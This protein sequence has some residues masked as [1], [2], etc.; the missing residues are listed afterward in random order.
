MAWRL[1]G[2]EPVKPLGHGSTGAITISR[3]LATGTAVAIKYLSKDVYRSPD[4]ADRFRREAAVLATVENPHLAQVYEYVEGPD[5]AA[6]VT[7]L[8]DGV[9]LREILTS[10]AGPIEPEAA[11]FVTMGA[12]LGLT[13]THRRGIV[14]RDV[15]PEN[16]LIDADGV[17]KVVDVGLAGRSRRGVPAGGDPRYLAPELWAGQPASTASDVYAVTAT[18]FECLTGKPPRTSDGKPLG[19]GGMAAERDVATLPPAEL[20]PRIRRLI[21]R[22]LAVT[23]AMRAADASAM[24]DDLEMAALGAY[25]PGWEAIGRAQLINRVA[26][27][28]DAANATEPPVAAPMAAASLN[29]TTRVLV[30]VGLLIAL[31][32]GVLAVSSDM[33]FPNKRTANPTTGLTPVF[34]HTPVASP[35]PAVPVPVSTTGGDSVAPQQPTGLRVTSRSQTAVS[36]DWNPSRDDVKV[37]GYIVERAGQRVGTTYTPGFIDVSLAANTKYAFTVTAF[38][39]A[40]NRSPNSAIVSAMTLTV[41]DTA[42]PT[43]PTGLHSTGRSNNTIVLAWAGSLDNIGVAGY[44][45]FRDGSRVATVTQPNFADT[46]LAPASPHTYQVRAFDATNNASANSAPLT[47]ATLST[48]DRQPPSVPTHLVADPTGQTAINLSWYASTDNVGVT[49]YQVFRDGWLIQPA[50]GTSFVDDGLSPG[51]RYTYTVKAF[52]AAGKVSAAS[53]GASATTLD[54]PSGPPTDTPTPTP[55]QTQAPT[56]VVL[57]V[58]LEN[59]VD[60]SDTTCKATIRATV[61]V[62][63]GPLTVALHYT[64]D[65]QDGD[66]QVPVDDSGTATVTLGSGDATADGT[67]SVIDSASNKGD[68]AAWSAPV[69]CL[70]PPPPP[71]PSDSPTNA[72]TGFA[73]QAP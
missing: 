40:G 26:P 1:P 54:A 68:S 32:V 41:P 27:L 52:D 63:G 58:S 64:I 6:I 37:A 24:L 5:S 45:V 30:A 66:V 65:G 22:D 8:V 42:S 11:F 29:R 9:S 56:P 69:A 15:K 28:L 12:L 43:V 60:V 25:G 59:P 55:T 3:D 53:A 2:Y 14:H 46:H 72:P 70:P 49:G 7:E 62:S 47:V 17:A 61:T 50:L 57:S 10:E 20:H 23:T 34:S 13:E 21:S 31:G 51:T 73:T 35:G 16:L 4:F 71:S 39:A 33:L 36:L 19:R 67:A 48:E 38:D 18:L 44:D